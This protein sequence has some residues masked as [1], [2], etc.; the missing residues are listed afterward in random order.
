MLQERPLLNQ[1]RQP[2]TVDDQFLAAVAAQTQCLPDSTQI[3][4]LR[5]ATHIH[6]W[7]KSRHPRKYAE[8]FTESPPPG[9]TDFLNTLTPGQKAT[10]SKALN[11]AIKAGLTTIEEARKA[12]YKKL[13][14]RAGP[15]LAAVVIGSFSPWE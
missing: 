11:A 9:W 6:Q 15:I 13:A 7:L 1:I 14:Q 3:R 12:E 5:P 8:H 4:N 2:S 10:L